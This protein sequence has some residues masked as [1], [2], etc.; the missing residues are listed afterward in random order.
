MLLREEDGAMPLEA[1]V[2]QQTA[3]KKK[4]EDVVMKEEHKK[5]AF[6]EG[7]ANFF[8]QDGTNGDNG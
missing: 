5:D 7:E 2:K 1:L 6:L 3:K 4:E 8:L